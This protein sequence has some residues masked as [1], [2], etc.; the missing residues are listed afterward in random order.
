MGRRI[1]ELLEKPV[2]PVLWEADAHAETLAHASC[3]IL[4]GGRIGDLDAAVSAFEAPALRHL[5]V[6]VHIDLMAG[7]ENS[8][9][10]LEYLAKLQ[11]VSGVV[12]IHH[13]LTRMAKRLRL[14]SIVRLFLSD[15]RAV[16]RGLSVVAKG[17]PDAIEIMPTA[18]APKVARDF[19]NC[20]V[21]RIAG[22]LCRSAADIQEV[23]ASG[24]RAVTSTRP[25][26]W[27]LNRSSDRG[28]DG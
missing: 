20:P 8:E 22:G 24:I 18:V 15:S 27:A 25:E 7:L 5:H 14:A 13:N 1:D 16:E 4:Q 3:V 26:L 10:G 17:K 12:T 23:M 28:R 9:A 2:I 11:R 19:A 6:L 21:P